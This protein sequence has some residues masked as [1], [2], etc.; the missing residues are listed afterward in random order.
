ML[1]PVKGKSLKTAD[2]RFAIVAAQYNAR[3]VDAMLRVAKA[4]FKRAGVNGI[5]VVRVPGSFEIP[6][7]ASRLAATQDV[8]YSAI[9]CLG[10]IFQGETSH[11][12]HI[13][14]AVGQALAQLQVR[15]G[16]PIIHAVLLFENEEQARVRCLGA[17]HNRGLEAARTAL[18]MAR[19]MERLQRQDEEREAAARRRALR[20][21]RKFRR[22]HRAEGAP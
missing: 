8:P 21:L 7:V 17:Q 11:A 9:V 18:T 14:Q 13:G 1:K 6:V 15:S 22:Q 20:A 3:Y 4:E 12:Q 10:V 5:E 19:V 2:G 16:V